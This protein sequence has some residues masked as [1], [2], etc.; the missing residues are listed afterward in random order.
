MVHAAASNAFGPR[1]DTLTDRRANRLA[2][3]LAAV[4]LV[5]HLVAL[6]HYDFFRDELYFIVC[7][8]HPAFGYADQP[9]LAPLIAAFTQIGGPDLWF[10]RIVPALMDVGMVLAVCAIVRVL[11]GGTS[12]EIIGGLAAGIAPVLLGVTATLTT[13]SIEPLTFTLVAYAA[14]RAVRGETRWWIACG[15][16]AGISLEQKYTILFFLVSLIAGLAIAGPRGVFRTRNFWFGVLATC[17]IGLPSIVWQAVNGWPFLHLLINDSHGKNTVLPPL[18]WIVQQILI[19]APLCAPVWIAGLVTLIVLPR[20]RFLGVAALLLEGT[21]LALHAKDYYLAGLY[22]LLFAAGAT[23]LERVIRPAFVRYAYAAL[24]LAG[25]LALAPRAL[26]LL[27][28]AHTIAYDRALG[29]AL[30]VHISESE[31]GPHGALPQYFADMHGWREIADRVAVAE[32]MLT[33]DERDHAAIFGQNYGEA[34]AVD[35]FGDGQLPVISG[36]N[37]YG[38]FGPHGSHTVLIIIGSTKSENEHF[39][40]DVREVARV[41]APYAVPEEANVPIFIAR[42]PKV[43]LVTAWPQLAHLY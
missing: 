38:L 33:A 6:T 35:F 43:D 21:F 13:T 9:P 8:R 23:G 11:G 7:G 37:Q 28:E 36:H 42:D 24:M 41:D 16:A 3:G 15:I 39:F 18:A 17:A 12:A 1:H 20:T 25:G 10:L 5:L 22:P 14:L 29:A 2:L 4:P 31:A 30:H 26:P 19:Y 32:R 27:D 34:A 40:R